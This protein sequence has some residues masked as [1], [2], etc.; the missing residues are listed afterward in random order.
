MPIV[1]VVSLV[2]F[3]ILLVFVHLAV[4]ATM[5]A[6]FGFDNPLLQFIF[7]LLGITFITGSVLVR[8]S[9]NRL[10]QWYYAFA[11][12]WFGLVHFLFIGG[13]AFFIIENIF[14][15]F[16]IYISPALIGGICFG[17][18]FSCISMERGTAVG[19]V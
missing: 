2:L 9:R 11:A 13:F 1:L 16:L 10:A 19:F 12:Y 7:I 3:Q 6:A 18:C 17:G 5:S 8:F 15:A 4:Y 14:N